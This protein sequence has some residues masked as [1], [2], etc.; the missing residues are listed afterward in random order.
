MP[1]SSAAADASRPFA[2]L[3]SGGLDSAVL[4]AE[5]LYQC[6]AVWPLYVQFGLY[7]EKTEL[8]HLRHFLDA[9]RAPAL[10]ALT[11]LEMPVADLYGA[12]WSLTGIGVP[13]AGTPDAAVY[14]PGRN[15]LLLAK[16]MM[17]CHL[18][19]VPTLALAPLESNPFP[20]ATPAFF[21]DYESIVNQA[22]GG[23]VRVVQPYRGLPKEEVLQRGRHLPLQ[24][25]FSCLRPQDSR[26]CG[27]CN[28]CAERRHAFLRAGCPDPTVYHQEGPCSA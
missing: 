27:A 18:H 23:E 9:I 21:T 15:V 20:D 7:W 24:W 11:V 28:K 4:L 22:I 6:P 5:T 13:E 2:V 25:T 16:A 17:W 3:V 14:L 1:R 26:H 10:R 8:Q 19:G 12:H